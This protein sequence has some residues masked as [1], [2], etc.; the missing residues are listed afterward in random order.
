MNLTLERIRSAV[1]GN[2]PY[3]CRDE[4]YPPYEEEPT[5]SNTPYVCRGEPNINLQKSSAADIDT[6][7][8]CRDE[9]G[10]IEFV[11]RMLR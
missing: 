1:A 3:V 2:T 4:P 7:Y 10:Q 11:K 9:P 8:V 6:P 5:Q